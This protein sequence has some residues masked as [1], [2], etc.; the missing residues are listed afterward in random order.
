[1]PLTASHPS[2]AT[3]PMQA[4]QAA[5][6]PAFAR[7]SAKPGLLVAG[8]TGALGSEVLRQLAGSGR[9]AQ[10]QVIAREPMTAG[11]AQVGMVLAGGEDIASWPLCQ[12]PVHTGVVMFEPSRLY[13]DRERALWTPQPAQLPALARWLLRCGAQTLVVILPHDQGRLPQ[14]LSHGLANID[15][16]V[17][18]ALGFQRVLLLRSA[19]KPA[20]ATGQ[21]VFEKL[22][23]AML[24]ILNYMIPASAMPVRPAKVAEFVDAALRV[25]PPGTHVVSPELLWQ[26]AQAPD[27][28]TVIQAW[29]NTPSAPGPDPAT[30]PASATSSD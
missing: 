14:A 28:H 17:V 5:L 4:L 15:E 24:S 26:A 13:H 23:A 12:T 1:M 22:A 18:A 2:P 25:L 7:A 11:L 29:L 20:V 19:Q 21:S 3:D 10:A 30:A 9:F 6:R 16:Q 27:L 8:A